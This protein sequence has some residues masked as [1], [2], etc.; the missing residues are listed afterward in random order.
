M[1]SV[2]TLFPGTRDYAAEHYSPYAQALNGTRI[3][4]REALGPRSGKLRSQEEKKKFSTQRVFA[5]REKKQSVVRRRP[6]RSGAKK[7]NA[8]RKLPELRWLARVIYWDLRD[9][10]WQAEEKRSTSSALKKSLV[11]KKR[12]IKKNNKKILRGPN[13]DGILTGRH[14]KGI[15]YRLMSQK[16]NVRGRRKPVPIKATAK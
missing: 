2:G 6:Y 10:G 14:V 15:S 13:D 8:G 5:V 4:G 9:G 1:T 16:W 12:T 7:G 11:H 3:Y